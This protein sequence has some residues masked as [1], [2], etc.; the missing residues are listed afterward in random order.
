MVVQKK[1]QLS[2]GFSTT[3]A[4]EEMPIIE[5]GVKSAF[6]LALGMAPFIGSIASMKVLKTAAGLGAK[7]KNSVTRDLFG[8]VG[9]PAGVAMVSTA[10][11]FGLS[12]ELVWKDYAKNPTGDGPNTRLAWYGVRELPRDDIHAISK[13]FFSPQKLKK[14]EWSLHDWKEVQI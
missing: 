2:R 6:A 13:A 1:F 11:L 14:G 9:V 7:T 10:K 8:V 4:E 12:Q 3:P 5:N